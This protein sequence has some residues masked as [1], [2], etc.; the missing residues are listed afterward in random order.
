MV[1]SLL[2]LVE[3]RDAE[4]GRHS[5]RTQQLAR[6]VATKLA[7]S[8]SFRDDLTPDAIEWISR[9]APLH[10]LGKIGVPDQIPPHPRAH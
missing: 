1:Q 2:S 9:L 10:D 8:P 6:L 4:T 7:S 5:R 3:T